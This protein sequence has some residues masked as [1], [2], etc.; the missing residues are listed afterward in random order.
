[1][2]HKLVYGFKDYIFF[3]KRFSS[4]FSNLRIPFVFFVTFLIFLI[5]NIMGYINIF[6]SNPSIADMILK[7]LIDTV[8]YFF[9]YFFYLLYYSYT[10]LIIIR[11]KDKKVSI[12]TPM[13]FNF[14]TI[15]NRSI[16]MLIFILIPSVFIKFV[17]ICLF[18]AITYFMKKSM[19]K[20]FVDNKLSWIFILPVV[21]EILINIITVM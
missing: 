3:Q 15:L 8:K 12:N 21:A 2:I 20:G 4:F 17:V 16:F 10:D 5:S 7:P 19:Y 14:L 11:R 18:I 1:M 13:K 6:A 9:I